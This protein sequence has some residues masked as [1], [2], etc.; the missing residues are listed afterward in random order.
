MTKSGKITAA[1]LGLG[2]ILAVIHAAN[3]PLITLK[4]DE[5]LLVEVAN[6]LLV[7]FI[8]ALVIERGC[9][10]AME[11]F[12]ALRVVPPKSAAP[13]DA[14]NR[15]RSL[16]SLVVCLLLASALSL[17]GLRLG[18]AV[19]SLAASTAPATEGY[20]NLIDAAMTVLLLAGGSEGV[21]QIIRRLLGDKVPIPSNA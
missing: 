1:I 19:L 4:T 17:A 14:A 10:V 9:E 13:E 8:L 2:T 21:H 12:Q 18:E 5:T 20:F 16:V 7:Y 6:I 3:A 15:E 11:L